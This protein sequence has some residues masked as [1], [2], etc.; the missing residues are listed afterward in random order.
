MVAATRPTS[1][2]PD[3]LPKWREDDV[4]FVV[5]LFTKRYPKVTKTIVGLVRDLGLRTRKDSGLN[6]SEEYYRVRAALHTAHERG[7]I[8]RR[9]QRWGLP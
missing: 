9:G 3:E 1:P 7:L 8:K 5:S 2:Q 4:A 6:W